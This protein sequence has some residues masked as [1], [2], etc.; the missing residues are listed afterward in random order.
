MRMRAG[1]IAALQG[2]Y[3]P[4]TSEQI[5]EKVW[6]LTEERWKPNSVRR[7]LGQLVTTGVVANLDRD[8]TTG[9]YARQPC[10]YTLT[11]GAS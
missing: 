9:L 6:S 1:I 10:R 4:L 8:P 11:E 7:T 5:I 3:T 2:S